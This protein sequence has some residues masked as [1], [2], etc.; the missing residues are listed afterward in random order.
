MPASS[1]V[2]VGKSQGAANDTREADE[3]SQPP[4]PTGRWIVSSSMR[5]VT[6]DIPEYANYANCIQLHQAKAPN[7][8]EQY[9]P[10]NLAIRR[11]AMAHHP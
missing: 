2:E 9:Q 4:E 5:L 7:Q 11:T 3:G 1:A 6:C 10:T 8:H